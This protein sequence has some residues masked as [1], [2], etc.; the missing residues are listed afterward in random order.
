MS[1]Q[2]QVEWCMDRVPWQALT[3]RNEDAPQD[4]IAKRAGRI[5]AASEQPRSACPHPIGSRARVDWLAG[6]WAENNGVESDT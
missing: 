3:A 5:A 4:F 1:Q 6:W 2:S